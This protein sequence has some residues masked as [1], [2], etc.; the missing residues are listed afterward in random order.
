MDRYWLLSN[1][2]YGTWLPGKARGF[3]GHVWEH[4]DAD[5]ESDIRVMHNMPGTPC[6][7]DM[8]GLEQAAQRLMKGPPIHLD[9]AR[10]EA[11]LAQFLETATHRG[12]EIEAVAIMYNHFHI[13]VGV[14]GDPMPGKILGDFKSWATRKLTKMFGAPASQT[15]WTERGSKR[16]LK[17]EAARRDAVH[18]VLYKQPNP[19]ITWSPS[20][21]L[22]YGYP[23]QPSVPAS[24]EP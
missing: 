24:V 4:R 13:V 18:Y 15:W 16:K 5:P 12:W 14:P 17:D 20:T 9:V 7:E 6:D 21:G 3:I 8:P 23:P 2:C 11:T 19:L 10:A 1:T 22:H